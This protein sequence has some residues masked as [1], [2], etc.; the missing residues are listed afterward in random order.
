M[1]GPPEITIFVPPILIYSCTVSKCS[2]MGKVGCWG[3]GHGL[4]QHT[5]LGPWS[6]LA[7]L[8]SHSISGPYF[9]YEDNNQCLAH[10]KHSPFAY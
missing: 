10:K 2:H 9:A 7:I 6:R 1:V 8:V 4:W 5:G 3:R